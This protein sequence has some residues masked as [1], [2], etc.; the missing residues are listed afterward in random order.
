MEWNQTRFAETTGTD[1]VR[2]ALRRQPPGDVM[3]FLVH[4][5][6]RWPSDGDANELQR[7]VA[8]EAARAV[9]LAAPG[10]IERLWRIPGRRANYGL[11][12]APD[13]TAVHAAI[14]SLPLYPW[15][16]VE[17]IPLAEHPSDPRRAPEPPV[18]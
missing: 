6:V 9:E 14:S 18:G 1:W 15:L 7:L 3:E 8:A 10:T 16:D 4:I 17:V 11:W 13:A 12:S 5:E 2:P